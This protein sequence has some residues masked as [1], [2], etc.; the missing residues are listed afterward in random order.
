M[1][2]PPEVR[3]QMFTM[4]EQWQQSGVTQKAFC[5]QQSLKYHTFY[6]WYKCYRRRQ[7]GPDE[8][9]PSFR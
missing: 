7:A 1:R 4:I 6:Y 2:N 8:N 9:I 5:E 3:E